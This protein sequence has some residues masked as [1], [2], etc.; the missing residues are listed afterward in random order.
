MLHPK[1]GGEVH[2][3]LLPN[4]LAPKDLLAAAFAE[5]L[6]ELVV[7]DRNAEH[8]PRLRPRPEP[9]DLHVV[10]HH[11]PRCAPLEVGAEN[12][13]EVAQS[14]DRIPHIHEVLELR[15]QGIPKT[16][17]ED[18]IQD[19][20]ADAQLLFDDAVDLGGSNLHV[21]MRGEVHAVGNGL[22]P[23]EGGKHALHDP[24]DARA[25]EAA[26]WISGVSP[27]QR[28]D[29]RGKYALPQRPHTGHLGLHVR[30]A[31]DV[32]E[33]VPGLCVAVVVAVAGAAHHDGGAQLRKPHAGGQ[34]A[35]AVDGRH[36]LGY[37]VEIV[38]V[39]RREI[40]VIFE[41]VT[42]VGPM[43]VASLDQ[44]EGYKVIFGR[45]LDL[46]RENA[47][48]SRPEHIGP[49]GLLVRIA[50]RDVRGAMNDMRD[51]AGNVAVNVRSEA[52]PVFGDIAPEH[53]EP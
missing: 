28:A 8:L 41:A 43:D 1:L 3:K 37:L 14:R 13:Y 52:K 53:M 33:R 16:M 29:T 11:V 32:D 22:G 51:A 34:E 2:A 21:W 49:V 48:V 47:C 15:D 19:V 7:P 38:V 42:V 40:E 39:A 20:D 6:H 23:A 27:G 17:V 31:D 9:E 36:G 5:F 45:S 26:M 35:L 50:E 10:A 44:D 18:G 24:I 46:L 30:A 4:P 25:V 12:L